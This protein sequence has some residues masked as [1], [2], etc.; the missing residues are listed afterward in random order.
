MNKEIEELLTLIQDTMFLQR[1]KRILA[2][3]IEAEARIHQVELMKIEKTLQDQYGGIRIRIFRCSYCNFES[4][5][6][7]EYVEHE[8]THSR[9]IE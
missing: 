7:A 2:S 1:Q 8:K 3:N 4:Q 5:T 9:T 6:E